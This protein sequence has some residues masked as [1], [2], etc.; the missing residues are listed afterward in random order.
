MSEKARSI[1]PTSPTGKG[2]LLLNTAAGQNL[3]VAIRCRPTNAEENK[4]SQAS[5]VT[6]DSDNKT[7]TVC[8]GPAGKK[9]SKNY[10]FE[11][12]FG[13][14]ASQEEVFESVAR[15]IVNEA[16]AGYN[17]TIFAYGQTGIAII[18][19]KIFRYLSC[20]AV[21]THLSPYTALNFVSNR[22]WQDSHHG[23]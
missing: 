2:I 14:Q 3:N 16:L 20:T 11:K 5:A 23:G 18:A 15:P 1:S 17:C 8:F 6:C 10:A 19:S 21:L 13:A 4:S 7:L 9:V 12:C 22:H